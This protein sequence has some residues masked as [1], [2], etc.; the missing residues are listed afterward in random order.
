MSPLALEPLGA[1]DLA[2]V[3]LVPIGRFWLFTSV[4]M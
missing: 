2:V 3:P 4:R 1:V